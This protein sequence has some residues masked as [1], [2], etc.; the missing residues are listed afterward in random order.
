MLY[1]IKNL[2]KEFKDAL[3]LISLIL[4]NSF[5]LM[6]SLYFFTLIVEIAILVG[7]II[8]FSSRIKELRKELKEL[9]NNK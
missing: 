4:L 3:I 6:F 8:F 2:S 1:F 5:L 9:K 7:I